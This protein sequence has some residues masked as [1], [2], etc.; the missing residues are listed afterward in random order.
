MASG[1]LQQEGPFSNTDAATTASGTRLLSIT[2]LWVSA[3]WFHLACFAM[4]SVVGWAM[5]DRIDTEL[6]LSALHMAAATRELE[7]NGIHQLLGQCSLRVVLCHA[8]KGA[9]GAAAVA[10]HTETRNQVANYIENYYNLVRIHSHLDYVSP[11]EFEPTSPPDLSSQIRP[12][13]SGNSTAWFHGGLGPRATDLL[14]RGPLAMVQGR[15]PTRMP[16]SRYPRGS[17]PITAP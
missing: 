1:D 8:S 5:S 15:S 10:S 14:I 11:V 17:R 16:V 7:A 4:A 12:P 2:P 6:A 9:I 3:A 13:N